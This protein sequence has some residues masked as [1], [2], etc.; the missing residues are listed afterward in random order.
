M[1]VDTIKNQLINDLWVPVIKDSTSFLKPRVRKNKNLKLLTLTSDNNF[2]E[3]PRFIEENLTTKKQIVVWNHNQIIKFR[4]ET[5]PAIAPATVLGT[6]R[7]EN[8]VISPLPEI[9]SRFIPFDVLN[10]DFSSQDPQ[11]E[12]GRIER[13]I[14]SL[15]HTISHQKNSDSNGFVLIYTT[16]I[17]GNTLNSTTIVRNSNHLQISGWQGLSSEGLDQNISDCNNKVECIENFLRQIC[18]KYG[19]NVQFTKIKRKFPDEERYICS[20]AGLLKR[21]N[22]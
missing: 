21:G 5:E 9:L 12:C 16:I 10:L 14:L 19:Y 6:A 3:I 22:T 8:S 20:V 17:N 2:Q 11:S 1:G 4:L 13:E 7:Y 18:S 15:E